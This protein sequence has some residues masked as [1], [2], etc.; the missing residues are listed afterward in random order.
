[1]IDK[2]KVL[3]FDTETT[4]LPNGRNPSILNTHDW[5]YIVQLSYIIYVVS[6]NLIL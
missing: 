6:N 1:M 3:V 5:P 4:G 2:M